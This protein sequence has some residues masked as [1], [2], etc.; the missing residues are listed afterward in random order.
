MSVDNAANPVLEGVGKQIVTARDRAYNAVE[1]IRQTHDARAMLD[2]GMVTGAFADPR[3]M[4]AKVGALL[5]MDASQASNSE[6]FKGIIGNQVLTHIRA[7]G[8]NPS[9]ADRDYI[10]KVQGGQIALEESSL[11]RLLDIN[12]KYSRQAIQRFNGDSKKLMD[13]NPEQYRMIAPLMQFDEPPAYSPR[14]PAAAPG[15]MKEKYRLQ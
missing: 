1:A 5:G 14:Q 15:S 13:A 12:E 8:A 4:F 9:N 11:R 3:V 2:E 10:E 6:V 7:L